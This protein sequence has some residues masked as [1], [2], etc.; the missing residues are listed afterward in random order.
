MQQ[1]NL[2][3]VEDGDEGQRGKHDD[4]SHPKKEIEPFGYD[5]PFLD[6]WQISALEQTNTMLRIGLALFLTALVRMVVMVLAA[7]A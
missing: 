3:D 2:L 4:D 5:L 6:G 1:S 7:A